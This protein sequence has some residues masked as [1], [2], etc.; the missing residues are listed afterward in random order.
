M[1]V[2]RL[3]PR[4]NTDRVYQY[5]EYLALSQAFKKRK[6]HAWFRFSPTLARKQVSGPLRF[7]QF[8]MALFVGLLFMFGAVAAMAYLTADTVQLAYA[9]QGHETAITGLSQ[10][11][12]EALAQQSAIKSK[13]LAEGGTS[14]KD[15]AIPLKP[16]CVVL[17][18]IPQASGRTLVEQLYPLSR[19][20]IRVQP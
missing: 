4:V 5:H 8:R 12:A 9:K 16:D 1:S 2:P 11:T 20:L 14:A 3:D 18:N 10:S 17:T 19:R 6:Q 7:V 15:V 13:V